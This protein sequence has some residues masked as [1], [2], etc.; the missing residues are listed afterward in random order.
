MSFLMLHARSPD[1]GYFISR[2]HSYGF[3]TTLRVCA[4]SFGAFEFPVVLFSKPRQPLSQTSQARSF[5]WS[6]WSCSNFLMLQSANFVQSL[7]FLPSLLAQTVPRVLL[8][9]SY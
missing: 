3:R 5:D 1:L 7:G 6:L 2:I 4:T 9:P 8:P